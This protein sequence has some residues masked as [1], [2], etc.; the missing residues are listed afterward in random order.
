MNDVGREWRRGVGKPVAVFADEL[1]ETRR[2]GIPPLAPPFEGGGFQ[3][4]DQSDGVLRL[5]GIY[6]ERG[7]EANLRTP[8]TARGDKLGG[9]Y[10]FTRERSQ[11]RQQRAGRYLY[12]DRH[13]RQRVRAGQPV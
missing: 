6:V 10:L 9:S 2:P 7:I 1:G 3:L 8:S 5:E 13:R 4:E 11:G 12:A